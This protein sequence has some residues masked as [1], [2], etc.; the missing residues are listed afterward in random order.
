M[1]VRFISSIATD[2]INIFKKDVFQKLKYVSVQTDT[3]GEE[4]GKQL[5]EKAL[6]E[7]K[8]IQMLIG[9]LEG[10]IKC[11]HTTIHKNEEGVSPVI[12]CHCDNCGSVSLKEINCNY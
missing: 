3:Y 7:L 6:I 9:E 1:N 12:L 10:I 2:I 4:T 5:I 11:K 8:G